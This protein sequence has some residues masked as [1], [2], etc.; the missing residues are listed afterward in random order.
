MRGCSWEQHGLSWAAQALQAQ[1]L[2][3]GHV[4]LRRLCVYWSSH[5]SHQHGVGCHACSLSSVRY[6]GGSVC[7]FLE[8]CNIIQPAVCA[9][10]VEVPCRLLRQ[11]V[12]AGID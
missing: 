12:S 8:P 5:T 11:I 6:R 3:Q 1:Q 10:V 4:H 9:A 2:S 7:I